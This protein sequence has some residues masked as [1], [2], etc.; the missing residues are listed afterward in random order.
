M[1]SETESNLFCLKTADAILHLVFFGGLSRVVRER[2]GV[3]ACKD[4]GQARRG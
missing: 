1:T 3:P 4:G 2:L